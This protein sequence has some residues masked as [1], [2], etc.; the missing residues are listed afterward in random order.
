MR[1]SIV[2]PTKAYVL[3]ADSAAIEELRRAL[4]YTNKSAALLVKRHY[5]NKNWRH[6]NTASWERRLE[7][8]KLDVQRTCVYYDSAGTYIR[9][10]SIPYL[11]IPHTVENFVPYPT[12]KGIPWHKPLPFQLHA[13]QTI[14]ATELIKIKHGNVELCTGSGKSAILLKVYRETGFKTVIVAPGKSIFNELIEKFEEHFGKGKIGKFGDSKKK[15]GMNITIAIADSLANIKPGSP[16]WEFFSTA[17]MFCADESHTW[18][19]ETLDAVAHGVLADVPYRMFFSAT[20]TRGD[21]SERLLYSIIGKTV[22]TLT[23][24]EAIKGGYICNHSF[25]IV[26]MNSS[27]P[28][29]KAFDPLEQKRVHLLGN[30]NIAEFI[31]RLANADAKMNKR[32]TLVLVEEL[33]QIA[34]LVSKLTVPFAYAHAESKKDRL[35]ELGLTKVKPAESVEKFNKGEAMV[36][37]GTSCIST[38]TNIFP[39]HNCCNWVGG[40]SEIKTKQGAVGRAVRKMSSSPYINNN[41]PK[42]A[43]VIWDFNVADVPLMVKHLEERIGYYKDSGTEIKYIKLTK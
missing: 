12:P 39:T 42:E 16:E 11:D 2:S 3:D 14:S 18:G 31:A 24:E 4:T 6:T 34:V 36:L 35:E 19:A 27:Q 40:G 22:H 30:D 26:E 10:G 7:E 13:Y 20:Q 23:T 21:G 9:P 33:S 29:H 5:N 28:N 8:L 1:F 41:A 38:G 17:E 25:K 37:I 43:S 15:L 32:Q